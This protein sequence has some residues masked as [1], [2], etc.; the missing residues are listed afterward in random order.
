MPLWPTV[1]ENDVSAV[2][3]GAAREHSPIHRRTFFPNLALRVL[4]ALVGV[5]LVVA[6]TW[7][8]NPWLPLLLG[9][10]LAF[11]LWE[12]YGLA[13]KATSRPFY[14]FG[15][16][17]SLLI[18]VNASLQGD[19]DKTVALLTGAIALPLLLSVL[20][21]PGERAFTDWAWT[22]LGILYVGWLATHALL[23]RLE[24]DGRDWLLLAIFTT[25]AVDTL[26]YFGGV[27]LGRR[28]LAPRISPAK[29]WE[30]ALTGFLGGV[31]TAY[32][33]SLALGDSILWRHAL[34][35][36]G[37]V[38]VAAQLGDLAESALKRSAGA[39]EAGGII[40]GHG[41]ILDRMDSLL[42]SVPPVYYYVIWQVQQ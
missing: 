37:V 17:W 33:L 28:K 34:I 27:A 40:P 6:A 38:G 42:L 19:S 20:R 35:L 3:Q 36:G 24:A 26:A 12:F 2:G 39:K 30:G 11:A 13:S 4:S 29:T 18:L 31:L 8:G 16:A 15:L 21:L 5:P 7:Y 32:L 9:F 1:R 23:L 22:S 10:A 41:G 14:P 25:F